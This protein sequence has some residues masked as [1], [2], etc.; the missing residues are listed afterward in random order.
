MLLSLTQPDYGSLL[1]P[2]SS[3]ANNMSVRQ[4]Q[5]EDRE[6]GLGTSLRLQLGHSL[7]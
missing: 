7:L 3:I 2:S 1:L 6:Q 4:K 5:D